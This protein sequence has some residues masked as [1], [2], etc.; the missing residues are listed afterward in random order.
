M[1]L[2]IIKKLCSNN[3]ILL[4]ISVKEENKLHKAFS[5]FVPFNDMKVK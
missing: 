1:L 3:N 5:I 2:S 4:L